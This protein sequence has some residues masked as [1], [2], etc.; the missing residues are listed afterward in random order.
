[1]VDY[2]NLVNLMPLI[3]VAILFIALTV[4]LVWPSKPPTKHD[5]NTCQKCQENR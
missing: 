5:P 2:F 1:M 3:L 4:Y